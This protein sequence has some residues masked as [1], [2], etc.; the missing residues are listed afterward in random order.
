MTH[1]IRGVR[2]ENMHIMSTNFT[3]TLVWKHE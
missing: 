3:K 2:V 1:K